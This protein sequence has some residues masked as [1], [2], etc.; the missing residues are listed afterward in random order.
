MALAEQSRGDDAAT[1]SLK[2][3]RLVGIVVDGVSDVIRLSD[4]NVRPPG[5]RSGL[6]FPILK[7]IS[8]RR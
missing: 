3:W 2:N 1:S 8:T 7:G 6:R 5:I 4:E